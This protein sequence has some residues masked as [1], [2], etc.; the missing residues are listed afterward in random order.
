MS[1]SKIQI[2]NKIKMPKSQ[3]ETFINLVLDIVIYLVIWI[4]SIGI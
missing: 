4:L 2:S 3:T 1:N